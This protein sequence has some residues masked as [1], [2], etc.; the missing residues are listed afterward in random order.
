MQLL[1]EDL[2][3]LTR[4]EG[5]TLEKKPVDVLELALSVKDSM[6]AAYPERV[7]DVVK[8]T[9]DVPVVEGDAARLRQVIV[10]LVTNAIK[11]AGPEAE[12]T[13]T[14]RHNLDRVVVD[15]ADDGVGMEQKD[16]EHIFERFYRA[17]ASRNRASG[18]GSGLGLAI[19]KSLIEAHGGTVAVATK[20]GEGSTFTISLPAA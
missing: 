20:P 14:I 15:I 17:D 6:H 10:N 16:A 5:S 2:L 19:T 1:V 4:A 8:D 11:H 7:I 12:V 13:I 18:G 9:P 3:A